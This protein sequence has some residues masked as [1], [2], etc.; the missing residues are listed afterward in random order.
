M[1]LKVTEIKNAWFA[2]IGFLIIDSN[3]KILY[4]MVATIWQFYILM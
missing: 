4:A 1:L 2:T 3:F